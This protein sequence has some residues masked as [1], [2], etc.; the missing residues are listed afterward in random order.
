VA[1]SRN[2]GFSAA[3]AAR[4][5]RPIVIVG[6]RFQ[7]LVLAVQVFISSRATYA[8]ALLGIL[9]ASEHLISLQVY[10]QERAGRLK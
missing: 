9:R 1:R 5:L 4:I 8:E 3:V 10:R 6:K 2:S 7:H